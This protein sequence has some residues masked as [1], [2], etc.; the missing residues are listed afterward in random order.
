MVSIDAN[1]DDIRKCH[2]RLAPKFK[3]RITSF[4]GYSSRTISCCDRTFKPFLLLK[5]PQSRSSTKTNTFGKI[6]SVFK[7]VL[8]RFP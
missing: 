7:I 8:L 1:K 4:K 6:N 5:L 3:F 2:F